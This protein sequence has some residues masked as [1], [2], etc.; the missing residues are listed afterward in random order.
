MSEHQPTFASLALKTIVVHTVTYFVCGLLAFLMAVLPF[1]PPAKVVVGQECD[2]RTEMS[3]VLKKYGRRL[4]PFIGWSSKDVSTGRPAAIRALLLS[5]QM[6][7]RIR[8]LN[9]EVE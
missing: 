5:K 7:K 6:Q 3:P 2:V 9:N 1:H 4:V 8:E